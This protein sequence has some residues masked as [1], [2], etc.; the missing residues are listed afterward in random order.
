ML[1]PNLLPSIVRTFVPLAVGFLLSLPIAPAVVRFLG[2]SDSAARAWLT[3]A[4]TA[5]VAAAYYLLARIIEVYV[6]PRLGGLMLGLP[7]RQ[8]IAYSGGRHAAGRP[9]AGMGSATLLLRVAAGLVAGLLVMLAVGSMTA[10]ARAPRVV[11]VGVTSAQACAGTL[12]VRFDTG[13]LTGRQWQDGQDDGSAHLM[14]LESSARSGPGGSWG[15][16]ADDFGPVVSGGEHALRW[17]GW[18]H[19]GASGL[20]Y[21]AVMVSYG[22]YWSAPRPV[23]EGCAA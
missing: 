13:W 22:G 6:K 9:D 1:P 12:V 19:A 14:L 16:P 4:I 18:A 17:P 7:G 15:S 23:T 8:P 2:A 21:T 11:H 10:S 20:H 5:V 3:Q